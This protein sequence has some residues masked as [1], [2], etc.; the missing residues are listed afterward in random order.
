MRAN[1]A[2][3]AQRRGFM[4]RVAL[5]SF[6]YDSSVGSMNKKAVRRVGSPGVV[7][8]GGGIHRAMDVQGLMTV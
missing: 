3:P 4:Q 6:M 1:I 5:C 8:Q 2:L 7:L